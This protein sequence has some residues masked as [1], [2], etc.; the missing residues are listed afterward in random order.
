MYSSSP[1]ASYDLIDEV[2]P[3]MP[4]SLAGIDA[5]VADWVAEQLGMPPGVFDPCAGIGVTLRGKMV[6]GVVFNNYRPSAEGATIDASIAA[7]T[8]RWATRR[9]LHD[10]FAYPFLQLGATRLGVSCRKSNKHARRFVQRL[11]FKMEGVGRRL[12]DGRHDAV[13]YSMLPEECRWLT[14]AR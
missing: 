6:A 8:A 13:V 9:V 14:P 12:W 2:D 7:T 5:V 3:D 10:F 1:A 4:T 11:G